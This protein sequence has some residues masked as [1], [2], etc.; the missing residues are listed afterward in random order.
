MSDSIWSPSPVGMAGSKELSIH[1]YEEL[2]TLHAIARVMAQPRDLR[3]QL[4]MVLQ[5]LSD[6]LGMQR[7]MISLI[8][9]ESG[10]AWLDVAHGIDIE[11]LEVT[12]QLGEGITGKVAQT[13]RPM[14]VANLG[15]EAH[16]L[17]RTGARRFLNRSE[18]AFLCVPIIYDERVVGVLS[19]DK[20]AR[21]VESLDRE[22]ATLTAVA[23][24]IAWSVHIR[25]LEEEN[26][27]LRQIV[28]KVK[29]P[30]IDIIG[31]SKVM[32][33]LFGL[34]AQVADSGTT[35]LIHG[36]TGTGKELVA[37]SIHMN[38][39]RRK[40]PL[41]QVNCA[42]IP[43]TLIESEL[44]G[45][46]KGAFTGAAARKRGWFEAADGG[47]L[48]LDE[49]GEMSSHLQVK[50]L[51]VIQERVVERVGGTEPIRVDFRLIAA[52]NRDLRAAVAAGRFREDLYYRLSVLSLKVPPLRERREDIPLLVSHF[53]RQSSQ[54]EGKRVT[55][56]SPEAMERLIQYPW[57][58]NVRELENAVERAVVVATSAQ[59][60]LAMLP[61][62]IQ[63]WS[64]AGRTAPR[65]LEEFTLE[66]MERFLIE[67]TLERT[68]GNKSEAARLL[69]VHRR[70]IY[71]RMKKYGLEG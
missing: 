61:E 21:H 41:V 17:D 71:N 53:L 19:A 1:N 54:R 60:S 39:S 52:T 65:P 25:S 16:F 37:R 30:S 70:S 49:I 68:G 7:G 56:L 28:G 3:D 9:R 67:K 34:I 55:S 10:E 4:E 35:V 63:E 22:V 43:D 26:R 33:E 11:G 5:E 31:S 58:G 6:R 46:E 48:F 51:R 45:H 69:K 36:E 27:R 8:D 50:L 32:Q 40:G 18:L 38:S 42:A 29:A 62:E 24:L 2:A 57:P 14:A 23:E 47:T 15:Q 12:Y 13:G 66:E 64:P 44:F 59:L 20:V